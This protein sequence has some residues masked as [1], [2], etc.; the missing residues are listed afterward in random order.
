MMNGEPGDSNTPVRRSSRARKPNSRFADDELDGCFKKIVSG[1]SSPENPTPSPLASSIGRF[2]KT[3]RKKD[4]HSEEGSDPKI[5]ELGIHEKIE[6]SKLDVPL[7]QSEI[8]KKDI[9]KDSEPSHNERNPSD[10]CET[11]LHSVIHVIDSENLVNGLESESEN[12]KAPSDNKSQ[13]ECEKISEIG[14]R[15]RSSAK[16]DDMESSSK[17]AKDAKKCGVKKRG[18]GKKGE[19]DGDMV[20]TGIVSEDGNSVLLTE[21]TVPLAIHKVISVGIDGTDQVKHE[22]VQNSNRNVISNYN[23]LEPAQKGSP[24]DIARISF[25]NDF[26]SSQSVKNDK[27]SCKSDEFCSELSTKNSRSSDANVNDK[28]ISNEVDRLSCETG[29]DERQ[30]SD[31]DIKGKNI[32]ESEIVIKDI[33]DIFACNK[34]NEEENSNK[35]Q[36]CTET[37]AENTKLSDRMQVEDIV[38]EGKCIKSHIDESEVR[39]TECMTDTKVSDYSNVIDSITEEGDSEGDEKIELSLDSDAEVSGDC[40]QT[41]ITVDESCVTSLLK[42][43]EVHRKTNYESGGE[44]GMPLKDRQTE[45]LTNGDIYIEKSNLHISPTASSSIDSVSGGCCKSRATDKESVVLRCQEKEMGLEEKNVSHPS[46]ASGDSVED[47]ESPSIRKEEK[48]VMKCREIL[49][50]PKGNKKL[51]KE[52]SVDSVDSDCPTP[53]RHWGYGSSQVLNEVLSEDIRNTNALFNEMEASQLVKAV[54]NVSNPKEKFLSQSPN[55]SEDEED[56]GKHLSEVN[57]VSSEESQRFLV[58]RL[59]Q[60]GGAEVGKR[61]KGKR[62][63]VT[64]EDFDDKKI[65]QSLLPEC[66]RSPK[67]KKRRESDSKSESDR[68]TSDSDNDQKRKW[69]NEPEEEDSRKRRKMEKEIRGEELKVDVPNV[70]GKSGSLVTVVSQS[71]GIDSHS[72]K[73]I[74]D[75]TDSSQEHHPR[76]SEG[77]CFVVRASEE[78]IATSEDNGNLLSN[79]PGDNRESFLLFKGADSNLSDD[80]QLNLKDDK[81]SNETVLK[82]SDRGLEG[83]KDSSVLIDDSDSNLSST[84]DG[85]SIPAIGEKLEIVPPFSDVPGLSVLRSNYSPIMSAVPGKSED[86][87]RTAPSDVNTKQNE[88]FIKVEH[89]KE[90]RD[91]LEVNPISLG[92]E[93]P[94]QHS[95]REV[96][97]V[98]KIVKTQDTG[99]GNPVKKEEQQEK[100]TYLGES[101]VCEVND[102]KENRK[103]KLEVNSSGGK[104]EVQHTSVEPKMEGII[105]GK[106]GGV[107]LDNDGNEE[108]DANSIGS[109]GED[110]NLTDE[111]TVGHDRKQQRGSGGND[112]KNRMIVEGRMQNFIHL[113]ENLYIGEKKKSKRSKEVRRMVCDCSLTKEEIARGEVG[114]GEDCLNRLLMIECGSRCPLRERC[115]NKRFQNFQYADVEVFNA[116]EKGCGVRAVTP[117]PPGTF[118]ME[119]VGEVFDTREF[120]RRRKEYAREHSAHF[121]FMALKSDQLIDATRKGN[122]SRFINH[123]CDPNAETQKWTVNGELRIGFFAKKYIEADE[124]ISFDY[125]LERYGR[126]P[127]RCYCG[128]QV[129]RGWL[130]ESP[131]EKTKEEKDEERRKE[132][133]DRRRRE[134]RRSFFEDIDLEDEIEKLNSHKLRN[135]QDTLNL[136][137]LMVRAEDFSSR[138][139]LLQLVQ[140]GEPACRRLFLDYHGL[141]VLWSWM[142]ALGFSVE[143]TALKIEILKTL[144]CLPITNKTQLTDSRVL[145]LVERW[146]TQPCDSLS[147]HSPPPPP[148]PKSDHLGTSSVSSDSESNKKASDTSE[149]SDTEIDTKVIPN[150]I[151][152]SSADDSSLDS[153]VEQPSLSAKKMVEGSMAEED[154]SDSSQSDVK[155]HATACI[156]EED[157]TVVDQKS[158]DQDVQE[159]HRSMVA[160]ALKLLDTWKNLK[161][162]FRIPKKERIELMK[163]HEREVD[164][165]YKEYLDRE[166]DDDHEWERDRREKDRYSR[167]DS[168]H[169][170]RRRSPDRDR[171]RYRRSGGRNERDV[172]EDRSSDSPKMS[173]EQRRQLFELKVQQEEEEAKQRKMQEEMW[174]MHVDRCRLLGQDPYLTPIFDPTYQ[175]YWDPVA[176]NWQPYNGSDPNIPVPATYGQHKND[177]DGGSPLAVLVSGQSQPSQ[178]LAGYLASDSDP[179][180]PGQCGLEDPLN[181]ANIPLPG[182]ISILPQ[183]SPSQPLPGQAVPCEGTPPQGA[184]V[185]SIPLPGETTSVIPTVLDPSTTPLPVVE[186]EDGPPPPPPPGPITIQLPPR[187]KIA[188]DSDGHVY[189]Y[190]VKTRTSQWEPPTLEQHQQLEAD[191]GSDSDSS[192]S[193]SDDSDS[194]SSSDSEDFSSDEEE[195]EVVFTIERSDLTD[196]TMIRRTRGKRHRSEALVQERVISP[197]MEVDR[198]AARRE[199]REAKE[200]AKEEARFERQ[201]ERQTRIQKERP[202]S[203]EILERPVMTDLKERIEYPE[204]SEWQERNERSERAERNERSE[205]SE[206]YERSERQERNERAERHESRAKREKVKSKERAATAIADNSDTARRI[207]DTFR[208]KMATFIVSVLNPY[209]RGDCKEGRITC[210]EDFKYLARKLTH[211][212]MVKELKQLHSIEA[213]E[214]SD[215][216]KHKTRD[217]VRKY[218]AKYGPVFKRDPNDTKEY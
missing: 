215:S 11:S 217:F 44:L 63:R 147:T 73:C 91:N 193:S 89:S 20:E 167:R 158:S 129:C 209:R 70:E 13:S 108:L 173:K 152:G 110:F 22:L 144:E 142:A 218:M 120:K 81:V 33:Q 114:C 178:P 8:H 35:I 29:S 196:E 135:R 23:L 132:E 38:Q 194:T 54:E 69:S 4:S 186:N 169:D 140:T 7:D 205:R 206:R 65:V 161:E 97:Y 86:S 88:D 15:T 202:E 74:A 198:E 25:E 53:S 171:D 192:S 2:R 133:R 50:S 184:K 47:A 79:V 145:A 126:E 102:D 103:P 18:K 123:S 48:D 37:I 166:Q 71:A 62:D 104:V 10:K 45:G 96:S 203:L 204:R 179:A 210:T 115:T 165:G 28:N 164:R 139:M 119:Y 189:F 137:R 9:V 212:V 201:E 82:L 19:E 112:Q 153:E 49:K 109:I 185:L 183:A 134:E 92:S 197:I 67:M 156:K 159:L 176:A 76:M 26:I 87:I 66:L 40:M 42:D 56:L 100:K 5:D 3:A 216:V 141:K 17:D 191:L 214:C 162:F 177:G 16:K 46:K 155:E 117:L 39:K 118:I 6:K 127:Q 213:L 107:R 124:E 122:I 160:L 1:L 187:W 51:V 105:G 41:D 14:R 148:P 58:D 59:G 55:D 157:G 188:R 195:E 131:E 170:R 138:V 57:I 207:K 106:V 90:S 85:S 31:T 146:S 180:T 84:L 154:S 99:C 163:E 113:T 32:S 174:A 143:H 64:D 175:Y 149:E 98:D 72:V 116:D 27:N 43:D 111:E 93:F 68:A 60:V 172:R 199:R 128:T 181:P 75:L 168:Y 208:S 125:R 78:F 52:D 83:V 36:L 211:F 182:E 34:K 200:R 101:L 151:E 30:N 77:K 94:S 121:Y 24:S 95:D 136:S 21:T 150:S 12:E 80:T 130:G 61:K 190:H